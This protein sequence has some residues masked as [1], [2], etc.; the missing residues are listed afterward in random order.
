MGLIDGGKRLVRFCRQFEDTRYQCSIALT[1]TSVSFPSITAVGPIWRKTLPSSAGTGYNPNQNTVFSQAPWP[2]SLSHVLYTMGCLWTGWRDM[3][4][5]GEPCV[6]H[7]CLSGGSLEPHQTVLLLSAPADGN[8]N[9]YQS[10][11]VGGGP[12]LKPITNHHH[13]WREKQQIHSALRCVW[14]RLTGYSYSPIEIKCSDLGHF[15]LDHK[16]YQAGDW[17]RQLCEPA[18]QYLRTWL[19]GALA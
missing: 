16:C 5:A 3:G 6:G 14:Y 15:V 1:V 7:W 11:N 17:I 9:N 4:A 13:C 18:G 19:I 10:A 8:P 2:V 12:Y